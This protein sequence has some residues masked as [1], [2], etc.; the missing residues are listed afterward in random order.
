MNGIDFSDFEVV[1]SCRGA[2]AGSAGYSRSA[3]PTLRLTLHNS[4]VKPDGTPGRKQF[5]VGFNAAAMKASR[6]VAGDRVNVAFSKDR[7]MMMVERHPKGQWALS[8]I[9]AEK[10]DREAAIGKAHTSALKFGAPDWA[11]ASN[12][13]HEGFTVDGNNLVIDGNRVL[14]QVNLA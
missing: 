10:A 9:G 11:L 2:R 6:F 7:L 12:R 14:A 3:T 5:S 4:G 13:L 8:P 1:E